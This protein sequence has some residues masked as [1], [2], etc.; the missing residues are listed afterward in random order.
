MK[1]LILISA[2]TSLMCACAPQ[3]YYQL[4]KVSTDELEQK[5]NLLTF[6]NEDCIVSYNLWGENG[7]LSFRLYNKT[8]KD[9][10][11]VMP[12]SFFIQNDMAYD[13]YTNAVHISRS[14]FQTGK[15]TTTASSIYSI[16]KAD[17]YAQTATLENST[18]TKEMTVICIPPKAAKF[19][20]GFHLITSAHKECDDYNFNYPKKASDIITY[21][22]EDSPWRFR[23]RIA[24]AFDGD[25]DNCKY[26][27]N[28]LWV[29]YLQNYYY[30]AMQEQIKVV[31]CESRYPTYE[32]LILNQAPNAFYNRYTRTI[33]ATKPKSPMTKER[34]SDEIYR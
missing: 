29:S 9:M 4:Y 6:E 5:N 18:T 27:D 31:P 3:S 32:T 1:K 30:S 7:D 19:F 21:V 12:Q 17:S 10:F 13:Y 25:S 16:G 14:V 15:S 2:I 28:E 26:I 23:N 33:G 34:V 24:Y 8:D 22:K 20:N 11:V